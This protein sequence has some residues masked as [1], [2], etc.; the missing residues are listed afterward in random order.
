M[1]APTWAT[2]QAALQALM[3]ALR[4]ALVPALVLALA[5]CGVPGVAAAQAALRIFAID[6]KPIGFVERGHATGFTVELARQIQQRIGRSDAIQLIPWARA[7]T[8]AMS[9]PNVLLLSVVRTPEREQRLVFVGPV[10]VAHVSVF[11]LKG[12]GAEF[13]A[14]GD[15]IY[16]LRGGAR[17]GSIFAQRARSFGYNVLDE[18][19][20]SMVAARMLMSKRFDLWFDGEE[21]VGPA[22]E[23]AGYSRDDVELVKQLS[24]DDAYL[25]FSKDTAPE[26]VRAWDAALRE[27]K[28][29]GSFQRLH[30]YWLPQ[31]ALPVDAR[32]H[33][34]PMP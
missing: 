24:V 5:C 3:L 1:Q 10:F 33:G 22:L 34:R 26:T 31:F 16:K 27:M 15:G 4:Q 29:D 12:R 2:L 20:N 23:T 6:S 13:R 21:L 28:R 18:P 30:Q 11:A 8:I 7:N 19:V 14:L 17:R 9:E 32:Q 25:A